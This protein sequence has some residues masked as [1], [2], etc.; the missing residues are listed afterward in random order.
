MALQHRRSPARREVPHLHGPVAAARQ[1]AVRSR[2]RDGRR[3]A[4]CPSKTASGAP[5][6][7]VEVRD[8]AVE[9]GGER[10][11][12]VGRER[13]RQD[14]LAPGSDDAV[15]PRRRERAAGQ[16][17][18]QLVPERQRGRRAL[19]AGHRA[20][21]AA[22]WKAVS[23]FPSEKERWASASCCSKRPA[24][25]SSSLADDGRQSAGDGRASGS[26]CTALTEAPCA[27]PHRT[28]R[29]PIASAWTPA[30]RCA[31]RRSRWPSASN[32]RTVRSPEPDSRSEPSGDSASAW[33]AARATRTTGRARASGCPSR[34]RPRRR[35]PP[36][37]RALAPRRGPRRATRPLGPRAASERASVLARPEAHGA[38]AAG[39]GEARRAG[40]HGRDRV[41]VGRDLAQAPARGHVEQPH[42]AVGAADHDDRGARRGREGS[43]EADHALERADGAAGREVATARAARPRPRRA[44]SG[45]RAGRRASARV[46]LR[47][48][49]SGGAGP[50]RRPTRAPRRRCRR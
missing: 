25:A 30:S 28:V 34:A 33:T 21:R 42:G 27:G 48:R 7:H 26:G 50:S 19:V 9:R 38:V 41:V 35:P 8:R 11:A 45:R 20:R 44:G 24:R 49:A 5:A 2:E 15:L 6:L 23:R 18:R 36:P 10:L 31:P 46:R 40:G 29:G 16:A 39:R 37:P 3:G 13:H 17:Q 22:R 12:A 14:R 32:T 1:A 47:W 43:G 4:S